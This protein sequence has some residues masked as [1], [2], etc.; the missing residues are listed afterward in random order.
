MKDG[1]ALRL[2]CALQ[3]LYPR[4]FRREYGPDMV[5]L[6]RAQ[7]ADESNWRVCTRALVDLSLTVPAC[8]VE[9]HMNRKATPLVV[10]VIT[11]MLAALSF[12]FVEGLLG[13]VVAVLGSALAV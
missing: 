13:I 12:G 7:L 8:H 2:Y 5:E 1:A 9:A 4:S 10:L 6:L 3:H 11:A